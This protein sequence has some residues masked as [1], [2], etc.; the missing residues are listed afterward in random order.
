MIVQ[1]EPVGLKSLVTHHTTIVLLEDMENKKVNSCPITVLD[2]PLG[3][4][5]VDAP[6]ISRQSADEC[7]KVVSLMHWLPLPPRR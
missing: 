2:R 5:K 7:G 6:R 1:D 3:L 4:Q